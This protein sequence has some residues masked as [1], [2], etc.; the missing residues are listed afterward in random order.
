MRSILASLRPTSALCLVC[1]A[2]LSFGAPGGQ[3][4]QGLS[5]SDRAALRALDQAYARAWFADNPEGEVLT[6]FRADAVLAPHHGAPPVEGTEAIRAFFWPPD[7]PPARVTVF[8]R[9]AL[10]VGGDG[11]MGYVR[12]RFQ[13]RFV[14]E[15]D[16]EQRTYSNGGN[17]PLLSGR[18]DGGKWR[19]THLIWNDPV[20]QGE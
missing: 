1:L 9:E 12:G 11:D 2:L 19:I 15:E 14:W 6:L 7:A 5:N 20:A 10:Q 17:Y 8:E 3:A 16:G 13:L 4:A 18:E